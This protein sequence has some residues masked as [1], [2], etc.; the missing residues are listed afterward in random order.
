MMEEQNEI[1]EE[2]EPEPDLGT[3]VLSYAKE[4]RWKRPKTIKVWVSRKVNMDLNDLIQAEPTRE[5]CSI[6]TEYG[7]VRLIPL[8]GLVGITWTPDVKGL[9]A[10][11]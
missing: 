8:G 2:E 4:S 5:W 1:R 7:V 9:E 3:A 10:T 6:T 11:V